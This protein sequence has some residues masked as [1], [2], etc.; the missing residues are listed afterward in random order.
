M[1][2]FPGAIMLPVFKLQRLTSV[3]FLILLFFI[4]YQ[5][6]FSQSFLQ[7]GNRWDY[8]HGWWWNGSGD[9]DTTS[10]YAVSDTT[11]PNGKTYY[12]VIPHNQPYGDLIRADSA[13]IWYYNINC[14]DEWLYY[15]YS[16]T[17]GQ[18]R[19]VPTIACDTSEWEGVI[20]KTRDTVEVVFGDTVRVLVYEHL[21]NMEENATIRISPGLGFLN[22]TVLGWNAII[23]I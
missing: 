10:C 16:D 9:S 2:L 20:T 19:I 3:S 12:I 11:L 14:S 23:T 7:V 22:K 21:L 8:I 4:S 17:I 6:A 5:S 1:K 18:V 15:S 13:G